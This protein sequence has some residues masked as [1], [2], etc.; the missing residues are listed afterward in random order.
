LIVEA[1]FDNP[2]QNIAQQPY[3]PPPW[4]FSRLYLL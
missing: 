4:V 1:L 2:T 3:Y